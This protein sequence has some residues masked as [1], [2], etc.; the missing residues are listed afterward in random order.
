MA[1]L[2]EVAY[3]SYSARALFIT[4]AS[5]HL[6]RYRVR[7]YTHRACIL[8]ARLEQERAVEVLSTIE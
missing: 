2:Q 3:F 8:R 5:L 6:E 7:V 4:N 1:L